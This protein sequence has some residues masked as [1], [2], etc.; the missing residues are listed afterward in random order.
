M[1]NILLISV[2][3]AGLASF[4]SPC[5]I[6][7][8]PVFVGVLAG[9]VGKGKKNYTRVFAFVLGLSV[10]FLLLGFGASLLG[11]FFYSDEWIILCSILI[12]FFGLYQLGI[13]KIRLFKNALIEP[14]L[15]SDN[16][17]GAFVLGILFSF[18]FTPCVGPVLASVLALASSGND[19]FYSLILMVAYSLG[20]SIPFLLIAIFSNKLL[21]SLSLIEKYHLHIKKIGG[22]IL[23]LVGISLLINTL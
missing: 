10:C 13:F 15:R 5:I 19:G 7:V 12:V 23:V 16:T 21:S 8:I 17:I 18:S 14:K 22:V 20:L 1:N 6:A 3:I 4:F 9:D 11:A 2:F